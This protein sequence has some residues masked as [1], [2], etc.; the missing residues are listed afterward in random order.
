MINSLWG[1]ASLSVSN[2]SLG[3]INDKKKK[4]T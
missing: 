2:I 3:H 4:E 1:K